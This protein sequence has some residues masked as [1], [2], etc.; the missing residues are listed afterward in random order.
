MLISF[1]EIVNSFACSKC[2]MDSW[3]KSIGEDKF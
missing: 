1:A 3:N 2:L